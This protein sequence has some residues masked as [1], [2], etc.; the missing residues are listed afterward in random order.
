MTKKRSLLNFLTRDRKFD[1]LVSTLVNLYEVQ[2]IPDS[3]IDNFQYTIQDP[4][5]SIPYLLL[6]YE[7]LK[8]KMSI[9]SLQGDYKWTVKI[10]ESEI[11]NGLKDITWADFI[12]RV[13]KYERQT[14]N[15]Y[16]VSY[17]EAVRKDFIS[18]MGRTSQSSEESDENDTILLYLLLM[19]CGTIIGSRVYKQL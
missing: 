4:E 7:R 6:N 9:D 11:K 16:K 3:T 5:D 12:D 15:G 1:S 19:F 2:I 13:V 17:N 10:S 8:D 14:E 18:E